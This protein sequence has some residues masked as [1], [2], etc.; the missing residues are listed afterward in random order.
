MSHVTYKKKNNNKKK[1]YCKGMQR[2]CLMGS[3]VAGFNNARTITKASAT[4]LDTRRDDYNKGICS[5]GSLVN[6]PV[7]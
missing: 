7:R 3:A 4:G 2:Q 6:Y 1:K 5:P